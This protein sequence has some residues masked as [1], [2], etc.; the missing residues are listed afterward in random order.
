MPQEHADSTL[1][2]NIC[3]GPLQYAHDVKARRYGRTLTIALAPRPPLAQ[4]RDPSKVSGY[5]RKAIPKA[6]IER[7]IRPW[8]DLPTPR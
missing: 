5:M 7:P 1:Q 2:N 8:H 3:L 4:P 6:R